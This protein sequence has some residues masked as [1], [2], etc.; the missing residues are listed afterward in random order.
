MNKQATTPTIAHTIA[1]MNIT[2]CPGVKAALEAFFEKGW[3]PSVGTLRPNPL[4]TEHA[5]LYTF[6]KSFETAVGE[7]EAL[8]YFVVSRNGNAYI[9]GNY[10]S[11][12][13]NVL[14]AKTVFVPTNAVSSVY[15]DCVEQFNAGAQRSIDASYARSLYLSVQANAF[16]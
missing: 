1:Q 5:Y 11:E 13:A 12:G 9:Q 16:A 4:V 6:V 8:V 15:A 2:G 3:S 10:Y 7:K 14:S